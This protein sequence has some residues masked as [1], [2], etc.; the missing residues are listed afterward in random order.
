[1]NRIMEKLDQISKQIEDLA[2]EKATSK[3]LS[4]NE[5]CA[6]LKISIRT[7]MNYRSKGI[8]PYS[9]IGSKIYYKLSD[10][11]RHLENNYKRALFNINKEGLN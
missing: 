11:E 10:L 2:N 3:W 7:M 1:M 8:I 5:S 6:F 9:K 4:T